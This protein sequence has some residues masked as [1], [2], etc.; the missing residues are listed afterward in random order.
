LASQLEKTVGEPLGL[1]TIE[2]EAGDTLG[3]G[4]I[5]VGRYITQDLFLSYSR[6]FGAEG[7]NT[8]GVEYNLNRRLKLKGESSDQGEAALQ[9]LWEHNY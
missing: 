4:S 5:R 1:D 7:S 3:T 9:L 8:A 2:I 6:E